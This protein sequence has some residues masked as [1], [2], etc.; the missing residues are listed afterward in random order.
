MRRQDVQTSDSVYGVECH[1]LVE[2][3]QRR[4]PEIVGVEICPDLIFRPGAPVVKSNINLNY[5]RNTAH[6]RFNRE[7]V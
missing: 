3:C 1:E 4:S 5:E 6:L 7:I 2:F